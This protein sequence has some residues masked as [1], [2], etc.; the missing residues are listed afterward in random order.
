MKSYEEN[1]QKVK[2][3]YQGFGEKAKESRTYSSDCIMSSELLERH[4]LLLDENEFMFKITLKPED[5]NAVG[6]VH[7]G[8]IAT[9]IDVFTT[10]TTFALSSPF[11]PSVSLNLNIEYLRAV[12]DSEFILVKCRNDRIG[13]SIIFCSCQV[14][15]QDSKLCFKGG[16]TKMKLA[17]KL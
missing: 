16:H 17:P 1:F 6:A 9:I 10:I 7:G 11:A 8:Y 14:Y 13:R 3:M 4:P 15:D 12:R 2:E 5:K